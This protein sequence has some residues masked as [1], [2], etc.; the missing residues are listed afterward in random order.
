[1]R[2]VAY[3][4]HDTPEGET[5]VRREHG[6][7]FHTARDGCPVVHMIA[8]VVGGNVQHTHKS[9]I[10][11]AARTWGEARALIGAPERKI[12][13]DSPRH[14]TLHDGPVPYWIVETKRVHNT[15]PTL[16]GCDL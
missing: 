8:V 9:G 3:T 14:N 4:L 11:T 10:Y 1:M 7:D 13:S 6:G 5:I 15:D 2:N 16:F 12:V